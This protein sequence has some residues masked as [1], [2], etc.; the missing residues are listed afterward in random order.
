MYLATASACYDSTVIINMCI[1]PSIAPVGLVLFSLR[2]R[3]L[4]LLADAISTIMKLDY[5]C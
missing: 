4:V 5:W 1:K 3:D 2:N